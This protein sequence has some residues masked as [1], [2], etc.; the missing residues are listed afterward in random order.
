MFLEKISPTIFFLFFLA[1]APTANFAQQ[2]KQTLYPKIKFKTVS[3]VGDL[4]EKTVSVFFEITNP[5]KEKHV[6]HII[7]NENAKAKVD[8]SSTEYSCKNYSLGNYTGGDNFLINITL[9][10]DSTILGSITYK[11]IP[12]DAKKL[13]KATFFSYDNIRN[14]K[15]EQVPNEFGIID[16]G[17]INIVWQKPTKPKSTVPH[18]YL[19]ASVGIKSIYFKD[20][21]SESNPVNTS[22]IYERKIKN[23]PVTIGGA[24]S[25]SS[26]TYTY[27]NY[28]GTESFSFKENAV[29]AGLRV[30][31]YFNDYIGLSKKY[32]TYVGISGGYILLFATENTN[33]SNTAKSGF[34]NG[35]H[36]GA[37]RYF[38]PNFG[39]WVEGGTSNL[40]YFNG[41]LSFKF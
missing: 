2:T 33:N 12:T 16:L 30:N 39:L 36:I 28:Y 18:Y 38:T 24:I 8:T 31:G 15:D 14:T 10:P 27:E 34:A 7:D 9:A 41:G 3:C 29:Y 13:S 26:H 37:R 35:L 22:I 25:Y 11:D 1:V 23:L 4:N 40:S 17:A 32:E 5:T 6:I 21:Y 20:G 19:S